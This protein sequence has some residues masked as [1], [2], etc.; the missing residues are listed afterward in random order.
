MVVFDTATL[1]LLLDPDASPPIDPDT[2]RPV[3]R[4][5]ARLDHLVAQFEQHREKVIVPTPTLS[6]ALVWAGAAGPAY[7]ETLNRSACFK[8]VPFDIRAAV[9]LAA[10][11]RE[12]LDVGDKKGGHAGSWAKVKFDRQIVAI[13]RVEGAE[14]IYSDDD[15]MRKLGP[16]TGLKVIGMN[17]LPLPPEQSQAGLFDGDDA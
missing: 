13:A 11:T 17:E 3:D 10:M 4:H 7:L 5:R 16:R 12:A 2:G 14:A 9:E 1:V 8:I 15:D 6:E